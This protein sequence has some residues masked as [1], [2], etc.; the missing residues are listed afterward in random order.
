MTDEAE[1]LEIGRMAREMAALAG[2]EMAAGLRRQPA[3]R[4]KAAP[5]GGE[6]L[7]D[8]VSEVDETVEVMIRER[9]AAR[10]P[11]HDVLGEELAGRPAPESRFLWA[12]D[13]VDGTANYINGFPL[14]AGSVGV[15]HDG[16]PIAGAVWCAA[17]HALGPGVYHAVR[18]GGLMFEGEALQP[19]VNPDVRRRLAGFVDASPRSASGWEPRRTG[20]AAI[21][22]AFVAAGLLEVARFE[23]PNLWDVAGGFALVEAAGGAVLQQTDDGWQPFRTFLEEGRDPGSWRRPVLIGTREAVERLASSGA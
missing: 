6:S 14:F 3:V 7:R 10:F 1:L 20:S 17:S 2:A 8:P 12:I 23:R 21:E 5:S 22:C 13:P 19:R 18:G 4:Y 9:L 16:V 15:L 11:H